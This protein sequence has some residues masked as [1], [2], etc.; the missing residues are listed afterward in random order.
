MQN[1]HFSRYLTVT[2]P[3]GTRKTMKYYGSTAKEAEMKRDEAKLLVK[4][5][6]ISFN[7]KTPFVNVAQ[8]YFKAYIKP[9]YCAHQYS[10]LWSM[11]N[12]LFI[13]QIGHVPISELKPSMIKMCCNELKG[14]SKS[15]I[16]KTNMLLNGIFKMSMADG[17]I[18][19]N[20]MLLIPNER[21][22][23]GTRRA[24]TAYERGIFF[25]V[26]PKHEKGIAFALMIGCGLRPGEVRAL[27]W[28][29]IIRNRRELSVIQAVKKQLKPNQSSLQIGSPKTAAGIRTIPIP[30]LVYGMLEGMSKERSGYVIRTEN[31][32]PLTEQAFRRAWNSFYRL[33]QIEAGAELYRNK[34]QIF[35]EGIGR[36]LTPYYLRHTYATML[37]ENNVKINELPYFQGLHKTYFGNLI[38]S[39]NYRDLKNVVIA[40]TP[41]LSDNEYILRY[42]HYNRDLAYDEELTAKS[43]GRGVTQRWEFISPTLEE[44][45]E[46]WIAREIYQA[47]KR[48]N[49]QNQHSTICYI[50]CNNFNAIDLVVNRLKNCSLEVI[51][52]KNI[53]FEYNKQE[54]Y[55]K[56]QNDNSYAN[57]FIRL[58]AEL[59]N[60][61][62]PEL[63]Y[64][65]KN[66]EVI[67]NIFS[68]IKLRTYLGI[69]SSA[70]FSNKVMNKTMVIDYCQTRC[71]DLKGKYIRFLEQ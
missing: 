54:E 20:P 53:K 49:R 5:G 37:A 18:S 52:D 12:R 22:Q 17:L 39:N 43:V 48:V 51:E 65:N 67:Q 10:M 44:I 3:D 7:S 71:I 36:D 14:K 59:Q 57:K 70:N 61:L 69:N 19:I 4:N 63:A 16:S 33:M 23:A 45:R 40:H 46:K 24:L 55:Q 31:G 58:L 2:L 9:S 34:I 41:N 13:A 62:H 27:T 11:I 8:Q 32:K 28:S 42:L 66:G 35:A 47:I 25:R 38:G 15:Y 30:D 6:L 29:N 21:G 60:G 50:F 26:L 64:M 56:Q 1:R 68:K